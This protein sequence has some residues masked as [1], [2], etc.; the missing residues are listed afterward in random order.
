MPFGAA[1]RNARR[2]VL[3]QHSV[4]PACAVPPKLEWLGQ[5]VTHLCRRVLTLIQLSERSYY[6]LSAQLP[7]LRTPLRGHR[8]ITEH[9][10]ITRREDR[11]D[12]PRWQHDRSHPDITDP[13]THSRAAGQ[14]YGLSYSSTHQAERICLPSACCEKP[15][16]LWILSLQPAAVVLL[17]PLDHVPKHRSSRERR[18][19]VVQYCLP[20]V[21]DDLN[22]RTARTFAG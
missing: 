18:G 11:P 8:E 13:G 7:S 16:R 1:T 5:T 9:R 10:S 20:K 21:Q 14:A 22:R 6:I 17:H 19:A 2:R 4:P 12:I 3:P 15:N